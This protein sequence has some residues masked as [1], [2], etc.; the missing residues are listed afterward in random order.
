V[1]T[2]EGSENPRQVNPEQWNARTLKI[3]R[4]M[5]VSRRQQ[6]AAMTAAEKRR[7]ERETEAAFANRCV[8]RG[9]EDHGPF[10]WELFRCYAPD[11]TA[12]G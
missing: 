11:G 4:D 2:P 9:C 12:R 10:G 8:N 7:A 5:E 1:S 3:G 6:T